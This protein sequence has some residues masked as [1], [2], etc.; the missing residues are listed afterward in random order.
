MY[1]AAFGSEA[2]LPGWVADPAAFVA[3]R[4][5]TWLVFSDQIPFWVKIGM[6]KVLCAVWELQR[7]SAKRLKSVKAAAKTQPSQRLEANAHEDGAV[8]E[9]DGAADK[10]EDGAAGEM[11][12]ATDDKMEGLT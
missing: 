11:E 3:Q 12:D 7:M 5:D 1:L 9:V 8:E 6:M 4:A 10:M 2:E